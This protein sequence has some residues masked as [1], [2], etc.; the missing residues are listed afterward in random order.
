MSS[1]ASTLPPHLVVFERRAL[2]S[3]E[4][5][6]RDHKSLHQAVEIENARRLRLLR[7]ELKKQKLG[8][9]QRC[10]RFKPLDGLMLILHTQGNADDPVRHNR[11]V[12]VY[13]RSCWASITEYQRHIF[14][15]KQVGRHLEF[16]DR[17]GRWKP[18][19]RRERP[20]MTLYSPRRRV[21]TVVA[22]RFGVEPTIYLDYRSMPGAPLPKLGFHGPIRRPRRA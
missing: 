20:D 11:P 14:H 19:P 17:D 13:C 18:V 12:K 15:V 6:I 8:M 5:A 10:T 16:L 21:N 22:A 4:R 1:T 7:V 3:H 9:C 2:Q